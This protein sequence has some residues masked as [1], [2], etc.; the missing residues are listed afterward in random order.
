MKLVT[1]KCP[2]NDASRDKTDTAYKFFKVSCGSQR[3]VYLPLSDHDET[4]NEAAEF[5]FNCIGCT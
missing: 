3:N 4:V 5:Q 2:K 1:G